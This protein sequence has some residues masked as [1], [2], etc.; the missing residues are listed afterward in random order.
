[1]LSGDFNLPRPRICGTAAVWIVNVSPASSL[2][3]CFGVRLAGAEG[4][5]RK[6]ATNLIT[7]W[8]RWREVSERKLARPIVPLIMCGGAGTRLWPASRE[9]RPKQFLPL[10]GS[11]VDVPGNHAPRV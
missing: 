5:S 10:F 8:R 9:N 11:A 3:R 7:E 6:C 2:T 1:M 4:Y